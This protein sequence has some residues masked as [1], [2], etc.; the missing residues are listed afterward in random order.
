MDISIDERLSTEFYLS[1]H[2]Y[3]ESWLRGSSLM[4]KTWVA[5]LGMVYYQIWGAVDTSS[6]DLFLDLHT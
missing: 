2:Y 1:C 6:L 3:H 4:M 5:F